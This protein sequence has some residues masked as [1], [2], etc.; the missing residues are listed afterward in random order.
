MPTTVG[1]G[2]FDAECK[3]ARHG[4]LVAGDRLPYTSGH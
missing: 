2:G 3:P 1:I 4:R